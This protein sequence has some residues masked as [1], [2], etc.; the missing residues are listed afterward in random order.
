MRKKI[1]FLSSC[2]LIIKNLLHFV[3]NYW[4]FPFSSKDRIL[5]LGSVWK[6]EDPISLNNQFFAGY[7][8]ESSG[9]STPTGPCDGGYYCPEGQNVST[10]ASYICTP[11][12][13][14]PVGSPVQI[15]CLSGTYQDQYG[16][17]FTDI[18]ICNLK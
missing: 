4:N 3:W 14:C 9:I 12:H 16:Q 17:V 6:F 10:P 11:G 7:Y 13:Y 18:F 2:F 5:S 15:S 1:H 8:C